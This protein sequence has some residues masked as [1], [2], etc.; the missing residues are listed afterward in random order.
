[1]SIRFDQDDYGDSEALGRIGFRVQRTALGGALSTLVNP[2]TIR[3]IPVTLDNFDRM[4]YPPP[5]DFPSEPQAERKLGDSK[6]KI[7]S[8]REIGA[9]GGKEECGGKGGGAM[10]RVDVE[11]EGE[12]RRREGEIGEDEGGRGEW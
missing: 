2:I 9:T 3:V 7:E 11:G 12:G 6:G 5:D 1:M 10:M 4:R 8:G